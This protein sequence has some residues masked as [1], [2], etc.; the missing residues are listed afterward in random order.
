MS[1]QEP[2]SVYREACVYT[3]K[4]VAWYGI[5]SWATLLLVGLILELGVVAAPTALILLFMVPTFLRG[6]RRSQQWVFA[7]LI[8]EIAGYVSLFGML[9]H[10]HMIGVTYLG[11]IE[12]GGL[13]FYVFLLLIAFFAAWAFRLANDSWR[14]QE[15]HPDK[16]EKSRFSLMMKCF[17]F[18]LI[19]MN[20]FTLSFG[21][22]IAQQ[23]LDDAML[24]SP[25][26]QRY[27]LT[28]LRQG[29]AG[30]DQNVAVLVS[31]TTTDLK[32]HEL[33]MP[34]TDISE[35]GTYQL[36]SRDLSTVYAVGS[37]LWVEGD[38]IELIHHHTDLRWLDDR[39]Q[40][41]AKV[42]EFLSSKGMN[43]PLEGEPEQQQID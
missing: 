42:S 3:G 15:Q 2:E 21:G 4:S 10:W 39:T 30:I 9:V 41:D 27:Q 24:V 13:Q 29:F 19:L 33:I 40:I 6:S 31:A 35:N 26:P 20:L 36:V 11:P 28:S 38:Q 37:L 8:Y 23:M 25:Q 16:P 32:W 12:L 43:A 34:F 7:F 22:T 18:C 17:G 5:S 14:L 1:E